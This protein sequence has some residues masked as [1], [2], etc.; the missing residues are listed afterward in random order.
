M[1]GGDPMKEVARLLTALVAKFE[2]REARMQAA[3]DQKLQKLE[4]EVDQLHQRISGIVNGAQARITEE[5]KVAMGPVASEYGRA[6]AGTSAQLR[7]ASRTVWTW[8]GGLVML[9]V[10]FFAIGWG[11][12]GYYRRELAQI[13]DELAR[14][15]NAVPVV[16]A[17]YASDA[18][19]CDGRICVNVDRNGKRSGDKQQYLPAKPR[20]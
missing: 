15:E 12:L 19:L 18:T 3:V 5:A 4:S 9:A 1:D 16:Q 10:L 14:Y 7:G 6:V 2:Q 11:V 17:F 13:Q 8:Y 20:Q